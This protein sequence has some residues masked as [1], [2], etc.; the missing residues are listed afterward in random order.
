MANEILTADQVKIVDK[1]IANQS[2]EE[3]QWKVDLVDAL[4]SMLDVP[5]PLGADY[6]VRDNQ[7]LL[8]KAK[9]DDDD[10]IDITHII[11]VSD[12]RPIDLIVDEVPSE[13]PTTG[14][15]EESDL[16]IT[17]EDENG[18]REPQI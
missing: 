5:I 13:E 14:N 16:E 12:G 6:Q 3:L 4:L 18:N 8:G 1:L 10:D 2:P 9:E 7:I 17:I 11:T 15:V